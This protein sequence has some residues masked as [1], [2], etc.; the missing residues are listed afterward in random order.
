MRLD[1]VKVVSIAL[2]AEIKSP[3]SR[4]PRLPD[5]LRFVIFLSTERRMPEILREQHDLLVECLPNL[6]WSRIIT[7]QEVRRI[8]QLHRA[9][10]LRFWPRGFWA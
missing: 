3:V 1:F 5:V 4:D 6:R 7:A 8:A 9:E 10:R 2:N